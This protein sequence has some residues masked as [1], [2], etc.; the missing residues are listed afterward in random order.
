MVAL[1]YHSGQLGF[2]RGQAGDP[3]IDFAQ[4]VVGVLSIWWQDDCGWAAIVSNSR[5]SSI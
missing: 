3:P 1:V 4:M 2:R 5:M